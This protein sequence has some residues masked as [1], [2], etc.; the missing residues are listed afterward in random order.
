MHVSRRKICS[1]GKKKFM[2]FMKILEIKRFSK[3]RNF[4]HKIQLILCMLV[5]MEL[6]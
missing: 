3:L 4:H 2:I 5:L 6:F 1:R